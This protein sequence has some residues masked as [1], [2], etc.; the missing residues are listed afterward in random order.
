MYSIKTLSKLIDINTDTIRTWERRY[1]LV[2]PQRTQTG[3]RL[4][5]ESDVERMGIVA[6]LVKSGHPISNLAGLEIAN[7]RKIDQDSSSS[8]FGLL[9]TR[10]REEIIR[11]IDIDDYMS[12][13]KILRAAFGAFT[14]VQL[15]DTI[16]IPALQHIGYRW[17]QGDFDIA[18]EHCFSAV[19]KQTLM[20][21]MPLPR[22]QTHHKSALFTTLDGE[23]HELGVLIGSYV[24]AEQ[25]FDCHYLGAN[26][27]INSL[28]CHLVRNR[29]NLLVV[30]LVNTPDRTA[31]IDK[32][33]YL[34]K[35]LPSDIAIYIGCSEETGDNL[36][37]FDN[38]FL[39]LNNFE[40]FKKSLITNFS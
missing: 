8:P 27:P 31:L 9:E 28:V 36:S 6:R 10:I 12:F 13:G 15:A 21:N 30:S 7:L 24:A 5:S 20:A 3:R 34:E 26:M 2:T 17:E 11:S 4:Y 23:H 16:L 18:Q 14:P 25:G 29:F 32:L 22:W 19:I 39:F 40:Q 33:A 1:G 38:R 37:L 35:H